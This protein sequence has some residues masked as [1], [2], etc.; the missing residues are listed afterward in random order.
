MACAV[1]ILGLVWPEHRSV[2]GRFR[3]GGECDVPAKHPAVPAD[4]HS[5]H[6]MSLA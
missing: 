3:S 4:D 1:G 6:A 5:E 2:F